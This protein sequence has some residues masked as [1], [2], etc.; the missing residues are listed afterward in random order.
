MKASVLLCALVLPKVMAENAFIDMTV[1]GLAK[2]FG[3]SAGR[4]KQNKFEGK[5]TS[6]RCHQSVSA[7]AHQ[8][9]HRKEKEKEQYTKVKDCPT[10]AIA[11]VAGVDTFGKTSF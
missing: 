5:R 9:G 8:E 2:Y 6:L 3:L 4:Q 10:K 1:H 7:P 11:E